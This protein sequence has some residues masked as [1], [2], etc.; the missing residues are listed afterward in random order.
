MVENNLMPDTFFI[1]QDSTE[2]S[3]ILVRRWYNTNKEQIDEQIY[4]RL[5]QEQANKTDDRRK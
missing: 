1:L 3:N 2:D 4:S 5:E